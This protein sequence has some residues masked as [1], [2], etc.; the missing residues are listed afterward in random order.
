[1][2]I[3]INGKTYEANASEKIL[4]VARRNR[5]EIPTLCHS[6]ALPGM[7]ACRLCMVEVS[8]NG[9][10]QKV[11]ACTHPVSEGLK[12]NT[13]TQELLQNR[14]V[15]LQM[16]YLMAPESK[17]IKSL[18]SYYHV[19]VFDRLSADHS[20]KCILCGLCTKACSELGT[21]AISTLNR[22]TDKKIGTAFDEPS[23]SCI[24]CGSCA[25][26]CPTGAIE[27]TEVDGKR[28]IWNK[29]FQLLR[30]S[31]CGEYYTTPEA[32]AHIQSKLGE[33]VGNI[34]ELQLCERCKAKRTAG[35]LRD[36]L[37]LAEIFDTLTE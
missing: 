31:G 12:I 26:V 10:K 6:D 15:L 4:D 2:Q 5:I 24:G 23:V 16:Y 13:D 34:E 21:D 33:N 28:T 36:S 27:M 1:M 35:K 8:Q 22:G 14:K 37:H 25:S 17:R 32:L 19:P 20:N 3:I 11:A 7:A 29:T 30:C 9:R 18:L